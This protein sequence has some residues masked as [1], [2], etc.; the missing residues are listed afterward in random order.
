M[1]GKKKLCKRKCVNKLQKKKYKKKNV[2]RKS[3][4]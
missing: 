1:H 2:I 3:K 4:T